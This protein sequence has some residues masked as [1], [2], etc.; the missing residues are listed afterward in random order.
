MTAQFPPPSL[1]R[2][3]AR[4]PA[5]TAREAILLGLGAALLA[6]VLSYIPYLNA[7]TYPIGLLVTIVHE[8]GH[9]LATL[10]TGGRVD[11]MAVYADGSG[12]TFSLGGWGILIA[13]AGYIGAAAYGVLLLYLLRWRA[14]GRP[15]L[16]ASAAVVFLLTVLFIRNPFGLVVGLA[17]TAA[18]VLAARFLP[19]AGA[20]FLVAFLG[21]EALLNAFLDLQTLIGLSGLL[22]SG[23]NDAVLMSRYIPLPPILWAL[24]WAAVAVF[25][26][27]WLVR[28]LWR[29]A[30][31]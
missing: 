31:R 28:G 20:I 25:L 24:A 1:D 3:D 16:Y 30:R 10:L 11:S 17:W 23:H 15:A 27:F 18:L 5:R 14:A 12:V 7:V 29:D 26:V 13:P 19:P 4:P 6:V 9:A 21:V 2:P 8:G 22:P